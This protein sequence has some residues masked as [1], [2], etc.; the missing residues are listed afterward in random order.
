MPR[1]QHKPFASPDHER[2]FP[3]GSAQVVTLDDTTIGLAR[4]EPG[5]RWSTHL[6]PI[7]GTSS[8]QVH[9]LGYAI[10]GLLLVVMDD[11]QSLEIPGGSAYEIPS[12]HDA[13][14]VG[15]EAWVTLEW[16]SAHVVGAAAEGGNERIVATVLFTDIVGSTAALEAMGDARWRAVLAEHNRRIRDLLNRHRG[17]ELATT[18]DGFLALFDSA[19]RAVRCGLAM[20]A[21]A[22]DMGIAIRVGVHTGEVEL[23]GDNARGLAVH[24]AARVLAVAGEGEVVVSETTKD[25]L[26]GSGLVV[27]DAGEHELKGISGARRLYRVTAPAG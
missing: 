9:H 23:V 8:C 24:A 12:G 21:S 19:S 20:A 5:W 25:L 27:E 3:R 6:A 18:G 10:S 14:V 11:G 7:A 4:W 26:E 17:R 16:T 15:D 2:T 13:S 22:T 1:L